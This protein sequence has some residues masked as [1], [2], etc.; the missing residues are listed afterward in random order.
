MAI[1]GTLQIPGFNNK[2][3]FRITCQTT[4][5][6]SLVLATVETGR[7]KKQLVVAI[8]NSMLLARRDKHNYN[9]PQ[10]NVC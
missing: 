10:S 5:Y 6:V 2:T 4:V 8:S 9:F 1:V 3:P 7:G